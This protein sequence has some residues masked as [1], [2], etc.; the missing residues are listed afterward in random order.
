[1]AVNL[2]RN[3][4]VY[5]TTNTATNGFNSTNTWEIQVLD[6]Y[7]FSQGTEQQVIQL[8]EAGATPNRGQRAFNTQLNPVE[9]NM[10]TYFRPIKHTAL[11]TATVST[12]TAAGGYA[13]ITTTGAHGLA[14]GE[15]V[16]ISG[17]H[18]DMNRTAVPI[19]VTATDV[20]QIAVASTS[21]A[22]ASTGTIVTVARVTSAER[23]LWNNMFGS[24]NLYALSGTP[25]WTEDTATASLSVA[26]SNTHQLASFELIFKVDQTYYRIKN[27]AVN[28][29][30]ISFS[31]NEIA[32]VAWS[33]FGTVVSE[34]TDGTGQTELGGIPIP[35]STA[36]FITNKLS[37]SA[38]TEIG[39]GTFASPS[40][41][42][43]SVPITGGSFTINNNI[44]YLTP[45]VLSIVNTPIGYYTG[46]RSITGTLNA[47]LRTG[48]GSTGGLLSDLLSATNAAETK[49]NLK[50]AIGGSANTVKVELLTNA[51]QMQIPTV[52]IQD[53]VSTTI[54]FTAQAYTGNA[55]DLDAT[56]NELVVN[57]YS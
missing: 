4:R 41:T 39:A 51:V 38:L 32:Q 55:Y 44:E 43:Y 18:A 6:G 57:Y 40:G 3:T 17:A 35:P 2:S 22:T 34:Y 7:T 24:A 10:T 54:N 52:D 29:A 37:T 48:A 26:Q 11:T 31:I 16:T 5:L 49:F 19:E 15:I 23:F 21:V 8:D 42:S 33:G 36:N 56:P 53:V 30:E 9:W 47:Y 28:Q 14:D 27:C 46:A 13:T 50:L 45:S 20:L 12:A 25:A 1:M